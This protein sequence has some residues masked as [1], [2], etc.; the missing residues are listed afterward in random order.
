MYMRAAMPIC[1]SFDW[2]EACRAFSRAWAKTGKRIAARMAIMAMT[3]RS[4]LRVNAV[5]RLGFW[6][7]HTGWA[8]ANCMAV[9]FA[10]ISNSTDRSTN[11]I[12]VLLEYTHQIAFSFA[13]GTRI[14]MILFFAP[15]VPAMRFGR[16]AG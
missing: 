11:V 3:T 1:R 13:I 2:Q 10:G 14:I 9:S 6:R 7:R 12:I 8:S 4:S 16:Q 15:L 5:C